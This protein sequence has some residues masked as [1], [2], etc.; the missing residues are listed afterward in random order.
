MSALI[1]LWVFLRGLVGGL[2]TGLMTLWSGLSWKVKLYSLIG[3][4]FVIAVFL[5]M[6]WA[7]HHGAEKV[8]QATIHERTANHARSQTIETHTNAL[9]DSAA[10]KRLRQHWAVK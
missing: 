6:T 10:R 2:L 4:L 9:P 3:G 7:S 1:A 8:V 5:A